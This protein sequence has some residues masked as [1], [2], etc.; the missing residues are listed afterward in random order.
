M[1]VLHRLKGEPFYLNHRH[2][3]IIESN[4]DTTITLTNERKYVVKETPE[5]IAALITAYHR[6][7]LPMNL[8]EA[9]DIQDSG[10]LWI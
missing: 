3:E 10:K 9:A 7:I 8:P 4:P 1:I 5:E 6:K 2:I